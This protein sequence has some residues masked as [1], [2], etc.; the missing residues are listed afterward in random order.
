LIGRYKRL[1]D[2]GHLGARIRGP[3]QVPLPAT[4]IPGLDLALSTNLA[5]NRPS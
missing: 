3:Q 1:S 2:R 4:G 5:G